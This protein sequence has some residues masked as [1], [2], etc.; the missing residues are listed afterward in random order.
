MERNKLLERVQ[1]LINLA[2]RTDNE[3]EAQTFRQKADKLMVDYAIEQA[4][5][6]AVRPAEQRS[7]PE[8]LWIREFIR[9]KST[10]KQDM[11]KA[12]DSIAIHC[13]CKAV[14]FNYDADYGTV[15][16][17]VFGYASDLRYFEMLFT[18]VQLH[19]SGRIEP[20][21]DVKLSLDENVYRLHEAGIKWARIADMLNRADWSGIYG[22]QSRGLK[23]R[24]PETA[25]WREAVRPSPNDPNMLIPWGGPSGDGKRLISAYKRWCKKIGDTPRAIPNPD[26]YQRGFAEGYVRRLQVRLWELERYGDWRGST[27]LVRRTESVDEALRAE[28]PNVVQEE[29]EERRIDLSAIAHGR[30]AANEV[31]L[32]GNKMSDAEKAAIE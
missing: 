5:L 15:S 24:N 32:T 29:A 1:S 27:A 26:A 16:A 6:D 12:L 31:D 3:D 4:E 23:G 21:P 14:F 22:P 17:K 19:M 13:R 10:I 9:A 25:H 28:F 18:V 8:S 2:E 30:E 7:T 20:T 11:C